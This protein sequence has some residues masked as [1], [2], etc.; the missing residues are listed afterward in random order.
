MKRY[1]MNTIDQK[2]FENLLQDASFTNWV[3]KRNR[4]DIQYWNTWLTNN[5]LKMN[6]VD[7][8]KSIIL[9]IPFTK[10]IISNDKIEK[11][12]DE[13]LQLIKIPT[14]AV[15]TKKQSYIS[16]GIAAVIAVMF[17][18]FSNNK[19]INNDS[20]VTHK[21]A[22]GEI[23]DLS[24]PD[25]TK[26]ILNGNSEISYSNETPRDIRLVGEAYFKVR[27]IPATKAKFWVTTDDL[28]VEVYGTQFHVNTRGKKNKC[29]I[30]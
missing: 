25:G 21:T 10:I 15:K 17:T 4:N 16:Y 5:E 18:L 14:T 24:L 12:L 27:P 7:L 26:V 9:G 30:R 22:Y 19:I 28:K 8:A 6:T 1:Q 29:V 2:L 20:H 23:I 11:E 3:H 13:V